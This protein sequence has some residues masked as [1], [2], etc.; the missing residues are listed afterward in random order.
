MKV[1]VNGR[2]GPVGTL[3]HPRPP[4]AVTPGL[5]RQPGRELGWRADDLYPGSAD[6]FARPGVGHPPG[7]GDLVAGWLDLLPL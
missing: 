4:G 5:D 7:D 1:A 6:G 2:A 3:G